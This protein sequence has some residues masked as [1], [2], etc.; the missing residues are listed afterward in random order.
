MSFECPKCRRMVS[1][2]DLHRI[3]GFINKIKYVYYRC[4]ECLGW[5]KN[6]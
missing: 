3:P 4:T 2:W 6:Q 1:Y 5:G